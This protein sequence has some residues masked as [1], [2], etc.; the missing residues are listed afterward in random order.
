ME[1][2]QMSRSPSAQRL[3]LGMAVGAL[4]LWPLPGFGQTSVLTYHYDN[5]RT[6]QNT[7]ETVLT[8][9][10]VKIPDRF[11]RL[12][13]IRFHDVDAPG[14]VDGDVFAQPLYMPNLILGSHT[15]Q[16]GTKHNVLFVVTEG[17]MVYA[18]DADNRDGPN[19]S[20]LWKANLLAISR[21]AGAGAIPAPSSDADS[22]SN[23]VPQIGIT[24][25]PVIDPSSGILSLAATT[26]EMVAGVAHYILRLHALSITNGAEWPS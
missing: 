10:R 20:P 11:A 4:L 8:P 17:D 16:A 9:A 14:E 12:F 7:H 19:A 26:K 21:G 18:F 24:G 15:P 22:C 2:G 25:T 6:G 1:G 13:T 5:T 3:F 23:L